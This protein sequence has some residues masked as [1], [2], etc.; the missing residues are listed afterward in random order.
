MFVFLMHT[1]LYANWKI[2]ISSFFI[3]LFTTIT[4]TWLSE[5]IHSNEILPVGYKERQESRW[6]WCLLAIDNRIATKPLTS[7]NNIEVHVVTVRLFKVN[8]SSSQ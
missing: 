7:P 1:A 2:T 8:Q 6:W 4:E 3:S 5:S